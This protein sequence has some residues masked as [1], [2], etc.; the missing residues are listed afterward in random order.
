MATD[1]KSH[2]ADVAARHGAQVAALQAERAVLRQRLKEGFS[3]ER[4]RAAVR[5]RFLELTAQR[6]QSLLVARALKS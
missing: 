3:D 6:E 1:H 4:L 5:A 2:R